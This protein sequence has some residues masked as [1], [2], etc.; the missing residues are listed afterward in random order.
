MKKKKLKTHFKL[1]AILYFS[2]KIFSYYIKTL[3][4]KILEAIFKS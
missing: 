1:F 4:N 3:N 2:L